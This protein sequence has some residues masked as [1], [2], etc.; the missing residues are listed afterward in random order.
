MRERVPRYNKL[1]VESHTSKR[2]F[3]QS[4]MQEPPPEAG[5]LDHQ[6]SRRYV[7]AEL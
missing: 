7:S 5:P 3:L 1:A 2:E 4:A 6:R